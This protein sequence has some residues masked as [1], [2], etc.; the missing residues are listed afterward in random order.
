MLSGGFSLLSPFRGTFLNCGL[1]FANGDV[2]VQMNPMK[3]VFSRI[4]VVH[5]V[6]ANGQLKVQTRSREF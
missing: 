1:K 4:L 6:G 2:K 3:S 5:N